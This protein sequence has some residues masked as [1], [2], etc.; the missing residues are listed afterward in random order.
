MMK[1]SDENILASFI[2]IDRELN[3]AEV[4]PLDSYVVDDGWN[5]YNNGHIPERDHERSGAV[6]NDKGF[7]TFNEKFPNQLTPS[8][9]LVQKFGSNFGVW[10]GPRGGYNFYGYLADI[11]TAAKTGSKAG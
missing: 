5:A 11:L 4:R 6:V 1:I 7:W 8:S 2:E 9:Q 10:V 3:K